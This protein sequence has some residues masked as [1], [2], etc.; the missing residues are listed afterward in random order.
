MMKDLGDIDPE[1][2]VQE[3]RER[4]LLVIS[5]SDD[6]FARASAW[7]LLDRYTPDKDVDQLQEEL[8]I[9]IRRGE[10]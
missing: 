8:E 3:N 1:T 2:Y 7:T 4:L 5:R 9:V 10:E 6:P